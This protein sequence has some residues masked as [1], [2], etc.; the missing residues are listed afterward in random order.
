[1]SALEETLVNLQ[2]S[3]HFVTRYAMYTL[4]PIHRVTLDQTRV[5]FRTFEVFSA[6]ILLLSSLIT[7]LSLVN[8][9]W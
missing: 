6:H 4:L 7:S 1:M 3:R 8:V 2:M 9:V 5:P